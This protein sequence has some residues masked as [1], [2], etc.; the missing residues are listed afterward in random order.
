MGCNDG[1]DQQLFISS[2]GLAH[3]SKQFVKGYNDAYTHS[4]EEYTTHYDIVE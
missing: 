4:L 1:E 3:H 2:G